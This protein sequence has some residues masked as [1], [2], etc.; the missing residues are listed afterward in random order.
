MAENHYIPKHFDTQRNGSAARC[1]RRFPH[2]WREETYSRRLPHP[3]TTL[4]P[5]VL[6][7]R[8]LWGGSNRGWRAVNWVS[9]IEYHKDL[10]LFVVR[11]KTC[12]GTSLFSA[13]KIDNG[14]NEEYANMPS[15][16]A[17]SRIIQI[18]RR[19]SR[20]HR[21]LRSWRISPN[22]SIPLRNPTTHNRMWK[23]HE[24]AISRLHI[25]TA[26]GTSNN[27]LSNGNKKKSHFRLCKE[28]SAHLH[29]EV[30]R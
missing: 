18:L 28:N 22:V 12:K 19:S 10:S 2:Y 15:S 16:T 9:V 4:E 23:C 27:F 1:E 11:S 6:S 30:I 20:I 17:G 21:L 24:A 8:F 14:Q 26:C 5:T 13:K 7:K 3:G 29:R 25:H